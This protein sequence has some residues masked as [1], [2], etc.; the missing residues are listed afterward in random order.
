[1]V[2]RVT[3]VR[4]SRWSGGSQ[5]SGGVTKVRRGPKGPEAP[6]VRRGPPSSRP[7]DNDAITALGAAVMASLSGGM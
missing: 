7:Y 2:R 4:R 1:M 6:M 3:K 5:R